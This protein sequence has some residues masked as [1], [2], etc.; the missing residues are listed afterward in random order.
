MKS[1]KIL[2]LPLLLL[3]ASLYALPQQ[4]LR[5][6]SSVPVQDPQTIVQVSTYDYF[7]AGN[8][9]GTIT[10][11]ELQTYGDYGLGTFDKTNGEMVEVEG[12]IYQA[13]ADGKVQIPD[14]TLKTP[15]AVVSFWEKAPSTPITAG[16]TM[17]ELKQ[18]IDKTA[19]DQDVF[20][21]I[22]VEG[23]FAT[24]KLRSVPE[25][26]KPYPPLTEIVKNQVVFDLTNVNG[27]LVGVRSPA[28]SKGLNAVGY[29]FHFISTD[30]KVG[31]HV[32]DLTT[33]EASLQFNE[34]P[35]WKILLPEYHAVVN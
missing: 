16:L 14:G 11:S 17:D 5:A 34:K 3:V 29:H 15:F 12:K 20:V 33:G 6:Q 31:G 25:Q 21:S 18:Q 9:D 22:R 1:L 4:T 35:V 19:P 8:L 24:L 13:T 2:S 23:T 30:R 28:F 27:T 10:L 7:A 32:L 26:T